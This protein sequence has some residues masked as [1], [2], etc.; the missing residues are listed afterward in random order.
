MAAKVFV[1]VVL[2]GSVPFGATA[3]SDHQAAAGT[4]WFV[5]SSDGVVSA[6][7]GHGLEISIACNVR[8]SSATI[9]VTF[10]K[11]KGRLLKTAR[12]SELPFILDVQNTPGGN[13]KFPVGAYYTDADGGDNWVFNKGVTPAFLDAFGQEGGRLSWRTADGVVIAS[14]PLRG[15][16]RARDAMRRVCNL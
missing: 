7:V 3:E 6:T 2:L 5:S 11:Y 10:D 13:Q 4:E 8:T 9:T 15:T 16:A 14:W 1:A 12:D